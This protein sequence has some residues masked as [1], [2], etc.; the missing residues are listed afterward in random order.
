MADKDI[1]WKQ[2]FE[3]YKKALSALKSAVALSNERNLSELEQQGLIQSFEFTHELSWKLLKDYLEY[4]GIAGIVGSRDAVRNAFNRGLISDA[5]TWMEMIESRNL[6]SHTYDIETADGI[7][8]KICG[9]YAKCFLSLEGE[10][11]KRE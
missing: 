6:T 8:K 3:N 11:E 10:M 2:R 7:A 9:K 5:E 4:Q 1:R